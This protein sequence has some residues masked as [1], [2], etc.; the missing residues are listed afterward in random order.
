MWEGLKIGG[1]QFDD[2]MDYALAK[3]ESD[4]IEYV[5]ERMNISDPQVALLVYYKLLDRQDMNTV[6]GLTF[7]K[8]LRDYCIQSGVVDDSQIRMIPIKG[9]NNKKGKLSSYG[10]EDALE[11]DAA[12]SQGEE[13]MDEGL[14]TLE[15]KI[16]EEFSNEEKQLKR[17]IKSHIDRESKLKSVADHYK[18]KVKK[19]YYVISAL[20]IIILILFILAVKSGNTPF[21][22]TEKNIQDKY[23]AWAEELSER[24]QA[25]RE[26]ESQLGGETDGRDQGSDS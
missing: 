19:C 3:K 26:K 21:S 8:Q 12:I 23:A 9:E 13:N 5:S 14:N 22:D 16:E 4:I 18:N 20:F 11:T 17:D 10:D 7:L 15:N 24:E 6:V 2:S 25:I 1:F